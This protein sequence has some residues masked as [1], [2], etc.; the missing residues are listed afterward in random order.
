MTNY[1]LEPAQLP[2]RR[3]RLALR[4]LHLF[5][6]KMMYRPLPGPRGIL[7]VYPHTSNW[8]FPI[9]LFSKWA[10]D[11]PFLWLG[12]DSLFRI[13]VLG[14]WFL[15]LGGQPVDRSAASGMIRAQAARMNAAPWYWLTITPEG[16][17]GYRPHWKSGFYHLAMEAQVPLCLVYLD[18][19]NRILSMADHVWLTGDQERD[20]AAIRAVYEGIQGKHPENAAPIVLSERRESPRN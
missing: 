7:V 12:K 17:R 4:V 3:Q 1:R 18:Y 6:W 8:D 10:V 13:P 2:T 5:G 15:A 11:L 19:A 14:K 9:G 16:T 20:M